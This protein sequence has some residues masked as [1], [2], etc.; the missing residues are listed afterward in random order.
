M[1]LDTE[2]MRQIINEFDNHALE[3][4][5]LL[6]DR[7]A[8]DVTVV[9]PDGPDVDQVL[10]AAA[11]KGVDRLVKLSGAPAN[12]NNHALARGLAALVREWQPDLVLTGVQAHDDLDGAV[13][14]LLAGYLGQPYVGYVAGVTAADGSVVARKE[15]PGGCSAE[16]SVKLPAVLGV[17]AAD[18]PPRYVAVSKIRQ[19]MQ[20]AA[21]EAQDVAVADVGGG[22]AIRRMYLPETTQG[23]TMLEGDEEAVAAQ[24]I[25]LFQEMGLL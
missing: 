19:A 18:Q 12:G 21:I 5:L 15:Y 4:A 9:A 8:G 1:A 11:A 17:Q 22:P 7:G 3:Q 16:M 10:F 23:A 6:K 2:W 13:G 20:T 14:P 25:D 24:L